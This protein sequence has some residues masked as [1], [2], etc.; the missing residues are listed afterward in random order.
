MKR[1]FL[2]EATTDFESLFCYEMQRG[3]QYTE[4]GFETYIRKDM[5]FNNV[6]REQFFGNLNSQCVS[7]I[8]I[9]APP[10]ALAPPKFD[11]HLVDGLIATVDRVTESES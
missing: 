6:S 2:V 8:K 3:N 4:E 7:K 9:E 11:G 1:Y 5:L 10:I